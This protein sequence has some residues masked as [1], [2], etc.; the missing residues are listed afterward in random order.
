MIVDEYE[1]ME[2][3]LDQL[4]FERAVTMLV[5]VLSKSPLN[6]KEVGF[7]LPIPESEV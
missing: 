4:K 2:E 1:P 6:N 3:G 5:I 7:Q